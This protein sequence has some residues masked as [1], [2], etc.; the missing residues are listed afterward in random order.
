MRILEVG[1]GNGITVI[2]LAR[3]RKVD[4]LGI[5]FAAEMIAAAGSI[6]AGPNLRGTAKF[7][8]GD[9]PGLYKRLQWKRRPGCDLPST[10]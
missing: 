7:Q 2:E 8:V 1:C 3:R 4:I 6:L 9:V 5:D 10:G